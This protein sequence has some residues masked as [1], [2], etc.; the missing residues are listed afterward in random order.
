LC[1]SRP[2]GL[3]ISQVVAVLVVI[4]A[5][6]MAVDAALFRRLEDRV[7]ERWGLR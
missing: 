7:R 6:G 3:D 4:M 1:S 5:M 2:S